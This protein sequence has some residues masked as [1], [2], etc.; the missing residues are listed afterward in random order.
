MAFMSLPAVMAKIDWPPAAG[1]EQVGRR[2]TFANSVTHNFS[3]IFEH[4]RITFRFGQLPLS[5]A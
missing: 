5:S 3:V 1:V 2:M 4:C